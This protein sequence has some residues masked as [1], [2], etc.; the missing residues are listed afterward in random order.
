[1]RFWGKILTRGNDYYIAEGITSNKFVDDVP[2]GSEAKGEGA[3][4]YTYWATHNVLDE[5]FELPFVTPE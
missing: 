3:N 4:T 1:M 2:A 5:W